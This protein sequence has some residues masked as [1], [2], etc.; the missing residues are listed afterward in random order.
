MGDVIISPLLLTAVIVMSH[1]WY[2]A[3]RL[4][5]PSQSSGGRAP[6]NAGRQAEQVKAKMQDVTTDRTKQV[7][8]DRKKDPPERRKTR[9]LRTVGQDLGSDAA[10]ALLG[11]SCPWRRPVC[12]GDD[13]PAVQ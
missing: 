13:L 11:S 12:P 7:K 1:M 6:G 5:T 8:A 3:Q 4:P 9:H 10:P 2:V